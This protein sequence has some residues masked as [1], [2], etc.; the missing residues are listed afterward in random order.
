MSDG[1]DTSSRMTYNE[2]CE[3][4]KDAEGINLIIVGLGLHIDIIDNL[5]YLCKLTDEGKFIESPTVKDL[6]FA[7]QTISEIIPGPNLYIEE[8]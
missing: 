5:R 8:L 3:R 4:L 2:I 7:F 1:E 6:E